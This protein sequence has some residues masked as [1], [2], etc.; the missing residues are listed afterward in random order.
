MDDFNYCDECQ[1]LELPQECYPCNKCYEFIDGFKM[2][3]KYKFKSG[4]KNDSM[5]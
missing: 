2:A 1:Y 3:T 4:D 5:L